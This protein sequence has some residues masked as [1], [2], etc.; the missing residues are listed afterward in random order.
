[1]RTRRGGTYPNQRSYR[2]ILKYGAAKLDDLF[3]QGAVQPSP[4]DYTVSSTK[5]SHR[6]LYAF[7]GF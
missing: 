1:M 6:A 4:I 5:S 7:S 2:L 3:V